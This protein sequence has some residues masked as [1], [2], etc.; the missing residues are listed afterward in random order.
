VSSLGNVSCSPAPAS[1]ALRLISCLT[2]SILR[3]PGHNEQLSELETK[4]TRQEAPMGME[5][6]DCTGTQRCSSV[7]GR[8]RSY[9]DECRSCLRGTRHSAVKRPPHHRFLAARFIGWCKGLFA[10]HSRLFIRSAAMFADFP[11]ASPLEC[12][13]S[14]HNWG[15]HLSSAYHP[16]RSGQFALENGINLW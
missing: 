15:Q 11:G 13:P 5:T 1:T 12:S 7:V 6:P 3:L 14:A 10:R 4:R 9:L 2:S 16:G 8:A